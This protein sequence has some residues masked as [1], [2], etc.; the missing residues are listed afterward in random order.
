VTKEK[1]IGGRGGHAKMGAQP[2]GGKNRQFPIRKKTTDLGEMRKGSLEKRKEKK[3][4]S[5]KQ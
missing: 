5:E 2:N 1:N 3:K 4:K